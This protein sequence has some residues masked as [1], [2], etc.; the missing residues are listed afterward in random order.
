MKEKPSIIAQ[1]LMNLYRQAH[2]IAGGWGSVNAVFVREADPVVIDELKKLPCGEKLAEHIK[3]LQSGRSSPDSIS[4]ELMPYGGMMETGFADVEQDVSRFSNENL[5]SLEQELENFQPDQEHLE[6]I[7]S[8]PFIVQFGDRWLDGV[9]NALAVTD[10]QNLAARWKTVHDAARAFE[11][12]ER[13]SNL[14][15]W[16]A[17]ERSRAEVQADLPEYETY[18]PL[19]GDAGQELLRRLRAFISSM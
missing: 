19:F 13:A 15:A 14:L 8:L 10:N 17:T 3:N 18:L 7:K 1:R 16:P 11:L 5:E 2:I 6:R 4:R 9:R 12:W